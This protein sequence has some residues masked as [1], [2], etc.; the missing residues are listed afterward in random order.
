[1]STSVAETEP[2]MTASSRTALLEATTIGTSLVPVMV[3][4]KF[5]AVEVAIS[6]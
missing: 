4:V 1:V 2:V 3:M 6:C 5:S